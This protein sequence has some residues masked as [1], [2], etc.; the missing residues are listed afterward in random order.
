MFFPLQLV[1]FDYL[2]K[3]HIYIYKIFICIVY[4]TSYYYVV[5]GKGNKFYF[6]YCIFVFVLYLFRQVGMYFNQ[7]FTKFVESTF[8]LCKNFVVKLYT[9]VFECL[10]LYLLL[11]IHIF[12]FGILILVLF[13]LLKFSVCFFD[14][15]SHRVYFVKDLCE[16]FN[17]ILIYY[18][19]Q[20][21][22]LSLLF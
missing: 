19:F 5:M 6:L 14:L 12:F 4:K 8:V 21:V 18:N 1:F 22:M 7:H 17:V 15:R 20:K 16:N 10:Q 2:L 13:L 11:Y 3:S 9:N